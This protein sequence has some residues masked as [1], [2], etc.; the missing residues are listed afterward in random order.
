MKK[1]V[2]PAL[3]V[4][5]LPSLTFAAT[6]SAQIER[7]EII[8]LG[9][10]IRVLR[11]PTTDNVGKLK[12]YD[13]NITLPIQDNGVP[14]ST[15]GLTSKQSPNLL[16]IG[17]IPGKYSDGK[18]GTCTVGASAVA[19]GRTAGSISCVDKASLAT[20]NGNWVSGPIKGH[21]FESELTDAG[22]NDNT[23]AENVAWGTGNGAG[24]TAYSCFTNLGSIISVHQ[25]GNV[26]AINN[27]GYDDDSLID[28]SYS[29]TLK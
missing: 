9:N 4:A 26:L 11:M 1:Y 5:M 17:F 22:I 23:G 29:F 13:L 7:A 16:A 20:F 24:Q 27:F 19:G 8:G 18:G 28:C 12:Y 21:P 6:P 10:K 14:S 15:P 3:L 2:M 25:A